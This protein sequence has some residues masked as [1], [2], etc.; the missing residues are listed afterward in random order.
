M[1]AR[2]IT[3]IRPWGLLTLTGS[4]L[5]AFLLLAPPASA[6]EKP[7]VELDTS[8]GKI[9]LELDPSKAPKTVENFLKYVDEG[10]YDGT[11]FHRVIQGF[12]IQGGGFNTSL[13]EKKTHE[14]VENESKARN[15]QALGNTRGTIAMARTSD[16]NSATAQFYINHA[17]NASLDSAGGGYTVFGKVIEGMNVVDKIAGARTT[18]QELAMFPDKKSD[19][20]IKSPSKDV[21][22]ANIV[23][24]SAKRVK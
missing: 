18:V 3:A 12:M 17:D 19:Q 21:P 7:K 14:P 4:A 5:A 13:E 11:V 23:I 8:E 20:R 9:V 16:P 1:N 24:K 2:A 22:A 15:P 6:Q 10:H